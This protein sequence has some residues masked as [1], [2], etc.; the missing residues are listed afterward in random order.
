MGRTQI[1]KKAGRSAR[2]VARKSLST[3]AD[4]WVREGWGSEAEFDEAMDGLV[5]AGLV[6]LAAGVD[7]QVVPQAS[8][9]LSTIHDLPA[10]EFDDG[11]GA[12][13]QLAKDPFGRWMP[14]PGSGWLQQEDGDWAIF[15]PQF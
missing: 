3:M 6:H 4:Q 14:R 10:A 11:L 15:G 9:R 7:G 13:L 8:V 1:R 5:Q 2:P 12:D